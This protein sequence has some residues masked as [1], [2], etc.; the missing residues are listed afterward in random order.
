MR[1]QRRS[2]S[3]VRAA[4]LGRL[5][6]YVPLR[7]RRLHRVALACQLLHQRMCACGGAKRRRLTPLRASQA[8]IG[9]APPR[10]HDQ[11][12]HQAVARALRGCARHRQPV[13]DV[14]VQQHYSARARAHLHTHSA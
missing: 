8:G 11:L 1:G 5:S 12:E 2:G 14:L 9:A 3:G 4:R 13:D 7:W 10:Q 6:S